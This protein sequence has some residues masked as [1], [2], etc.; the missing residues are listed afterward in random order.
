MYTRDRSHSWCHETTARAARLERRVLVAL[1]WL[2]FSGLR[3]ERGCQHGVAEAAA[4]LPLEKEPR[5]F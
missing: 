4:T 3:G 2:E 1:M 5:G